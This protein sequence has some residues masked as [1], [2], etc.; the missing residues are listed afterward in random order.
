MGWVM[1]RRWWY[2]VGICCL[3]SFFTSGCQLE[4][5]GSIK[6]NP[7]ITMAFE[8]FR[9]P[10]DYRYYFLNQENN[11][12]GVVGLKKGYWIEGPDWRQVAPSS[13]TF[14]KVVELVKSFPVPGGRTAGFS[15]HDPK[16]EPIGC[17]YS[18]L[19]AGVTVDSRIQR[20]MLTTRTPWLQQ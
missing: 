14:R 9:V 20:V 19:G 12:F 2:A 4:S 17:W 15:I 10:A 7:D 1:M 16:G 13:E 11:P 18:S 5:I 3:L 8:S 6:Q